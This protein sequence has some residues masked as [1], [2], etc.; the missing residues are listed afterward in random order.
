[1]TEQKDKTM[2]F[3]TTYADRID[4][5]ID[6]FRATFTDSEG[7]AE[8]EVIAGFVAN[9]FATADAADIH[10]FSAMEGNI[11]AGAIIFT[12]MIYPDDKRTVFILSPVAVATDRQGKGLGQ[13][14]INFGLS[15]LR[16]DGV[17]VA[18]TYGDINFYSRVGFVRITEAVA[19]PPLPL[20]HPEGWLGQSLT[21]RPLDP[22]RGAPTCVAALNNPALW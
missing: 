16:Q 20:A 2:E 5:I 6:I 1:M 18:L 22:L 19:K 4:A 21:Q 10:V 14:L 12:R 7:A 3:T 11:V 13:R 8:G 15:A 17:D 9:I